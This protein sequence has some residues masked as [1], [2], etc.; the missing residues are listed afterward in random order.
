MF[1]SVAGTDSPSDVLKILMLS[2]CRLKLQCTSS[3]T[4]TSYH[5]VLS[6]FFNSHSN[7]ADSENLRLFKAGDGDDVSTQPLQRTAA[8]ICEYQLHTTSIT[9]TGTPT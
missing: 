4:E 5:Q 9:A 8:Y 1:T 2:R 6:A 3:V 7:N